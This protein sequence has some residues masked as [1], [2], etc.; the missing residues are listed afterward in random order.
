MKQRRLERMR[1]R[2]WQRAGKVGP[3]GGNNCRVPVHT[4]FEVAQNGMNDGGGMPVRHFHPPLHPSPR[5][6]SAAEWEISP[7]PWQDRFESRGQQREAGVGAVKRLKGMMVV[8]GIAQGGRLCVCDYVM[9]EGGLWML[10]ARPHPT[11]GGREIGS[12]HF[13]S[14]S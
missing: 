9:A 6:A 5:Q 11:P 8:Y 14:P 12:C 1:G 3:N 10:P 13:A 7:G 2:T 4:L